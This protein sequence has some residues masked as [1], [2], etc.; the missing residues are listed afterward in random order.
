MIRTSTIA[1]LGLTAAAHAQSVGVTIEIDEPV[2]AP[3][4]F[5]TVRLVA[6]FPDTDYALAGVAMS[7]RFDSPIADARRHWSDVASLPPFDGPTT[8]PVVTDTAIEGLLAGQL[9][10][11]PAGIYADPTNPVAFYEATFTAPLDAG[12]FY[13]VD[14]FTDVMRFDAYIDRESAESQSRLD[15]LVEDAA[16]IT[17]I[18]APASAAV[19]ALGLLA[20]RRR[21]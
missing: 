9:N 15:L 21:R 14:L 16:T 17:V 20:V 7:L 10:F 19:L 8:G 12:R 1:V 4:E 3:G 5:T 13:E 6:S 2:L 11:P 18:P